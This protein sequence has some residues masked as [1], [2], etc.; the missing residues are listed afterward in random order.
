MRLNFWV[1]LV[2]FVASAGFFVW[3]QFVR[4]PDAPPAAPRPPRARRFRRFRRGKAGPAKKPGPRMA[5]PK[6]RVR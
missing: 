3:W 6:G 4:D 1:S 5:V 2:V